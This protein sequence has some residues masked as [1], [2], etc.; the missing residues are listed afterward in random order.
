MKE[1]LSQLLKQPV[2]DVVKLFG[3]AS[4]RAYY[5]V[6]CDKEITYVLMAMPEGKMS[7]S[8]EIT[9]IKEKPAELP[10]INVQHYLKSIG[11]PVPEIILF[12]EKDRWLVLED[13]GNKRFFDIVTNI[14]KEAKVKWYKKAIDLLVELQNRTSPSP[15]ATLPADRQ[16]SPPPND[17]RAGARGEGD[18]I[19]FQRSYDAALFNWE[20]DHFWEYFFQLP[21]VS[22]QPPEKDKRLF[23]EETQKITKELCALPAGF[24][25]RDYQSR[26]LMV[27]N[28][29]LHIIDFQDAL[30]GP[31]IYDM[32]C[33]LRDSYVDVT[34]ILEELGD[35]YCEKSGYEPKKFW[36]AFWLQ[37][38]Q[39]KLKDSGRFVFIDKVKKNPNFLPFI[40]TSMDYVRQALEKLPEYGK[41]KSVIA[42]SVSDEAIHERLLRFARND[43]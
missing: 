11:M 17:R 13:L 36:R 3:D 33:L 1:R 9:N 12:S 16:P 39:R 2:N 29:Q 26:N 10:Y 6:F 23:K 24:T 37:T 40:P 31:K 7:V 8:E 41:L 5:R 22:S 15:S 19:A 4:Y 30:T 32:V 38:V 34:D 21:A 28:D 18:C 14:D 20:F 42:R 25:H 43:K 27:K 35:Y